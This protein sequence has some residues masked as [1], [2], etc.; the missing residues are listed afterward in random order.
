MHGNGVAAKC[1]CFATVTSGTG[2]AAD[3]DKVRWQ[4]HTRSDDSARLAF[5][6]DTIFA[7]GRVSQC[8]G[9]GQRRPVPEGWHCYPGRTSLAN[10]EKPE[11][12]NASHPINAMLNYAYAV[13]LAQLQI[14]AVADGYDPTFGI[15]HN[16]RRGK[17]ALILD[18]IEPQ[19]PIV[20]D[21]ILQLVSERRF[22]AADFTLRADG[23][24]RLS[25]QLARMVATAVSASGKD[26]ISN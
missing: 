12:R 11:N 24:Y 2:Y 9:P 10:G 14:R 25:P 16:G 13:K 18:L 20:D 17:P 22:A 7:P 19:R 4:H 5:A 3:R 6:A 26:A 8:I 15:I 1:R 21:L 23:V